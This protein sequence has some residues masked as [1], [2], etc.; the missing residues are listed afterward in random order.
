MATETGLCNC[1]CGE[2]TKIANQTRRPLGWIKGMPIK[3][4]Q[5]HNVR[6]RGERYK[7]DPLTGCWVWQWA[8]R[9]SDGYGTA[10]KNRKKVQAH[11]LI[12]EEIKGQIPAGLTLDHLCR[13]IL[14]VNPDHLEPVTQ[15]E[16][17]LRGNG[18]AAIHARKTHCIRGHE[19][20]KE[21]TMV[22][23]R[24]RGCRTCHYMRAKN[25]RAAA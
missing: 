10:Y 14:C 16:N 25:Y 21:N 20:N 18:V 24:G 15:R 12:Y 7:A 8:T 4:L 23:K 3:F 2:K 11:R 1:G 13:N 5:G 19:F 22:V 9:K 17:V 6:P